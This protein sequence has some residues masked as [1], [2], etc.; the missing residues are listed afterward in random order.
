MALNVLQ[1]IDTLKSGGAQSLLATLA[2]TLPVQAVHLTVFSLSGAQDTAVTERLSAAGVPVLTLPGRHLLDIGRFT[3]LVR[4]LQ[5]TPYD[6]VHTHLT[7]ANI[8][9]VA[10]ARLAR[11]PVIASLHNV[12]PSQL[13]ALPLTLEGVFL[14]WGAQAIVAVGPQVARA[15]QQRWP[16]LFIHVLPNAVTLLPRLAKGERLAQRRQLVGDPDRPLLMAIG[17]LTEQ[18]G[19][20]DLLAAFVTVRRHYPDA[21]LLIIGQGET[22][23]ALLARIEALEL[24]NSV[25][26]LGQRDDVPALLAAAD[27]F[28]SAS[29]WEGMPVALLEAMSAGLPVVATAVGDVPSV[30]TTATGVLVPPRQPAALAQ[31]I[32]TLLDDPGQRSALG[33]A[34]RQR[35]E[36]HYNAAVWAQRLVDLYRQQLPS[37]GGVPVEV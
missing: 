37:P 24:A 31:A 20:P 12:R 23:P 15:Y 3:R 8:L 22:R 29:H 7:Y 30:V 1:V 26:L 2:E 28:V 35:V 34:G 14:R 19:Y 33:K 5:Q 27:L 36:R 32:T 17:R 18:K 16:D 11:R 21:I 25:H 4:H 13:T 9:G 6:L 10:A